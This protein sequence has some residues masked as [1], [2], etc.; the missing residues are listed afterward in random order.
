MIIELSH[1]SD[2]RHFVRKM[3]PL[4]GVFEWRGQLYIQCSDNQPIDLKSGRT[5]ES[6]GNNDQVIYYPRATCRII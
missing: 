2:A 6:I 1:G 3:V 5:T 4:G